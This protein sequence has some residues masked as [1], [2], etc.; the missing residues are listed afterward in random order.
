MLVT[1]WVPAQEGDLTSAFGP[2]ALPR[3]GWLECPVLFFR[4]ARAPPSSPQSLV[5]TWSLRC[6]FRLFSWPPP[7][8]V[9]HS[10]FTQVTAQTPSQALLSLIQAARPADP[11][12]EGAPGPGGPQLAACPVHHVHL[13]CYLL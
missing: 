11:P 1:G 4:M 10:V 8:G 12:V 3:V 2:S 6:G 5:A 7:R 9:T 13:H